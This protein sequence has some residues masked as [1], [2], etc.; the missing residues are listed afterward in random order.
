MC[1]RGADL[2][3][4]RPRDRIDEALILFKS[5]I[6]W[7]QPSL[8]INMDFQPSVNNDGAADH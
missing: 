3:K 5:F 4:H 2:P 8:R 7:A 6:A 1:E